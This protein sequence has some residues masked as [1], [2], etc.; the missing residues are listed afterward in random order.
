MGSTMS[1]SECVCV[2]VCVEMWK[3]S[4]CGNKWEQ[5]KVR[6]ARMGRV[7]CSTVHVELGCSQPLVSGC[8]VRSALDW[9]A[10]REGIRVEGWRGGGVERWRV[11]DMKI[12]NDISPSWIGRR[13]WLVR[14]LFVYP[15]FRL[16]D[17][18]A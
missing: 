1:M 7:K 11:T 15:S 17:W 3:V 14:R 16:L 5:T 13:W 6:K 2:Y 10:Q 18:R 4:M 9:M 8:C 12:M